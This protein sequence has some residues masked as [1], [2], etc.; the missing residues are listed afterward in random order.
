MNMFTSITR[1]AAT[2]LCAALMLA[3][4]TQVS[5][6]TEG[7]YESPHPTSL[8]K[9]S[10]SAT[11]AATAIMTDRAGCLSSSSTLTGVSAQAMVYTTGL[12]SFPTAGADYLVLST[13][14]ASQTAGT[15]TDYRSHNMSGPGLA[16][17][18]PYSSPNNV[19]SFD[20][21]TLSVDFTLPA[22]S[23]A[24]LSFDWQFLSEENPT[25]TNSFTDYFRADVFD[26][27]GNWLGNIA[28]LPNNAQVTTSSAAAY[29]NA[30]GGSSASPSPPFPSP[31]D[32]I[33][34]AAT[35]QYTSSI[36]LS[37]YGGQTVTVQ[38]RL[39][40]ARD[41]ILNSAVFLDNLD[42]QVCPMVADFT[43]SPDMLWPPDH[44][45]R[46]ITVTPPANI[47]A[48]FGW[49]L[50]SV[51]SNEPDNGEE[52]GNTID[53]IQNVDAGTADTEFDLRAERSGIGTGR[54]Y[55]ATFV[56]TDASGSIPLCTKTA[57]VVVPLSMAPKAR[58]A[59]KASIPDVA[60]LE[61]NYPNPFNPS[62][63]ISYTLEKDA[64]VTL[65]V[66]D[67]FGREVASLLSEA[68][69]KGNYSVLF[70]A[71]GLSSGMYVYTLTVDGAALNRTM[72]LMK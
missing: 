25:Y 35:A 21:I 46:T 54:V 43:L 19:P 41:R 52:D 65:R 32:V 4:I 23:S 63:T 40:D 70:D 5:A 17:N 26:G 59:D 7:R 53:D 6:Q 38:F 10:T 33:Y 49:K 50:Q 24:S 68:Q 18:A 58:Y 3:G 64:E 8:N 56:I 37:M 51:V 45:M 12:Q 2:G 31:N 62:T 67:M 66:F 15:A 71:S 28:R 9:V 48:C 16:A 22:V 47:P 55:T 30:P 57:Q 27:N 61:Q 69:G 36:D 60:F 11:A 29:S 14:Y 20:V 1:K 72:N 44:K 39:A 13:G 42:L 34:N